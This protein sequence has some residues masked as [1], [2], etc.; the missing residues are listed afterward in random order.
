MLC[1]SRYRKPKL[2]FLEWFLYFLTIID[3]AVC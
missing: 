3:S 1:I 2:R